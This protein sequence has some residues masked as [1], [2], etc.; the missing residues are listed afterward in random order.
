MRLLSATSWACIPLQSVWKLA[1]VHCQ[2][3]VLLQGALS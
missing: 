2:H 1:C 3:Q